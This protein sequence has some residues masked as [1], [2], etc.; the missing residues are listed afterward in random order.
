MKKGIFI[1]LEGID[2]CGKSTQIEL[3]KKTY[4]EFVYVREPGGTIL[5]EKIRNLILKDKDITMCGKA[6]LMLFMASRVEL[7]EKVIKPHLEKGDIVI[8]DRYYD[9]TLA[10]QGSARGVMEMDDILSLN[11]QMLE[12]LK[13]DLTI[14]L[15]ISPKLAQCRRD[16][17]EADKMEMEGLS[18]QEKVA[19]GYDYIASKEPERF[20]VLDA[21]EPIDVVHKNI[22]KAI[23]KLQCRQKDNLEKLNAGNSENN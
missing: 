23:L 17:D 18:F 1:T 22:A 12:G 20:L 4:P 13:P 2:A 10:Y 11:R 19:Q 3:L 5:G 6:E 14:Y 9:S 7:Y 8:A 15:K 21:R 16:A